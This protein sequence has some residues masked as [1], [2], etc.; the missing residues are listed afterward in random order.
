MFLRNIQIWT[1]LDGVTKC[2][3]S[4]LHTHRRANPKAHTFYNYT[5]LLGIDLWR[6]LNL[7]TSSSGSRSYMKDCHTLVMGQTTEPFQ[8][9]F[10]CTVTQWWSVNKA[11]P[12][13][14]HDGFF[15]ISS[16]RDMLHTSLQ[17]IQWWSICQR[18]NTV[19]SKTFKLQPQHALWRTQCSVSLGSWN[20]G[21]E[22]RLGHG[23]VRIF[24]VYI[25]LYRYQ[26]FESS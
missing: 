1:R 22:S 14:V 17:H 6:V 13:V 3:V 19:P 18:K 10:C 7:Q 8:F 26:Y 2:N 11:L 21:F 24:W 5:Y 23:C 4:H 16:Y 9:V 15:P 25:I 12:E 20:G